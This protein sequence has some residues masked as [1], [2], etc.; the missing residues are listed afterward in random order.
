MVNAFA[1][2]IQ[3][4]AN[5]TNPIERKAAKQAM[6]TANKAMVTL[7][8]VCAAKMYNAISRVSSY[9]RL[10]YVCSRIRLTDKQE[11]EA[12]TRNLRQDQEKLRKLEAARA[13][14]AAGT[15]I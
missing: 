6:E 1:A 11:L 14:S 15:S 3:L 8:T 2:A 5:A 7:R 10:K 9:G 4:E 13:S 12:M